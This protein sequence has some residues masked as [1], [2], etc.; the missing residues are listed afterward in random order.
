MCVCVCLGVSLLCVSCASG[1]RRRPATEPAGPLAQASARLLTSQDNIT[2]A[3]F[4]E[5]K[6]STLKAFAHL[7]VDDLVGAIETFGGGDVDMAQAARVLRDWDRNCDAGS[8]GANL[9]DVSRGPRPSLL[10]AAAAQPRWRRVASAALGPPEPAPR[11]RVVR[12]GSAQ[13][14]QHAR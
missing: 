5:L 7:V 12:P 11:Q 8:A 13:H 4:V 1:P 3:R 9:F 10:C 2:F 6:H 14:A